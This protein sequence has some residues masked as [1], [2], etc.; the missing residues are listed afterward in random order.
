MSWWWK[1]E[2]PWG[3]LKDMQRMRTAREARRGRSENHTNAIPVIACRAQEKIQE[4]LTTNM[5]YQDT[6]NDRQSP[7]HMQ[8]PSCVVSARLLL[9]KSYARYTPSLLRH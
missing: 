7:S 4:Y 5:Q 3:A 1:R 9:H 8:S 6:C 2:C